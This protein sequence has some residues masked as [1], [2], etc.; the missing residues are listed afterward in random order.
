MEMKK[1]SR[2]DEICVYDRFP[3]M[4]PP[5]RQWTFSDLIS[6]DGSMAPLLLAEITPGNIRN[7]HRQDFPIGIGD[8]LEPLPIVSLLLLLVSPA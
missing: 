7:D 6:R 1:W 8:L 3:A 4:C 5:E 2:S